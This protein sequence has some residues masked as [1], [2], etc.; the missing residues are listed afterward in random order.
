MVQVLSSQFLLLSLLTLLLFI[1]LAICYNYTFYCYCFKQIYFLDQLRIRKVKIFSFSNAFLF[2]ISFSCCLQ[3]FLYLFLF[4]FFAGQVC[5]YYIPSHFVSLRIS[6]YLLYCGRVI[7]MGIEFL[8]G[9]LFL[10]TFKIFH[11]ILFLLG[12]LL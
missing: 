11:A 5:W 10:S 8:V 7:S 3:N 6:L 4:F 2:F 1:S 9:G 12:S